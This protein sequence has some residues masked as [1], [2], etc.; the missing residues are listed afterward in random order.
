MNTGNVKP[1]DRGNSCCRLFALLPCLCVIFFQISVSVAS[2]SQTLPR[3][4]KNGG[5]LVQSQDIRLSC[6]E[7]DLFIPGSTLK[8]ATALMALDILSEDYRFPTHFY[9][10]S[11]NNLYIKG[12]GDPYLTSEEVLKICGQLKRSGLTRVKS[13]FLDDSQFDLKNPTPGGG[14]STNPYDAPNGAIAVNFNSVA[15]RKSTGGSLRSGESQTPDLPILQKLGPFVSPGIERVQI[16]LLAGHTTL[17]PHLEYA[18]ELFKAQ[19][20]KTGIDV[21]GTAIEKTTPATLKPFLVHRNSKTLL[22]VLHGCLHYSN[23]F[24]ANQVLLCCAIQLQGMPAT[25]AKAR[26]TFTDYLYKNLSLSQ[27]EIVVIDGSGLSRDN[28]MSPKAAITILERFTKYSFMLSSK[29]HAVTKS[30]TL[31]GVYCY[32]G[33]FYP[34]GHPIP[35]AIFLNQPKNNRDGVLKELQRMV[36]QPR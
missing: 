30:G 6:R 18:G 15:V 22:E 1:K 12:F 11:D 31:E 19:L 7:N 23:N 27:K 17:P 26:T 20:I 10:D 8:I 13:I 2:N 33:Y 5:Y 35:F 29:D 9:L 28:K 16:G 4:I 14:S 21:T 32:A 24:I 36:S 34:K 25:W 3:L